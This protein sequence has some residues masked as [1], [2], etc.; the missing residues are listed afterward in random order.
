MAKMEISLSL[1]SKFDFREGEAKD[2]KSLMIK[3]A[4]GKEAPK[5]PY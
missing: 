4:L 1:T 3:N 5:K 2:M